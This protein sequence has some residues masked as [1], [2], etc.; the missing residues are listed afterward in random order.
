M[1]SFFAEFKNFAVR[2]NVVELAV[3]VIIGTAFGKIVSS[4]VDSIIMPTI[5]L[6]LG[7]INFS[8]WELKIGEV[9]IT[10]GKFIQSC[11]DFTIVA[12]VIFLAIKAMQRVK[13]EPE[14]ETKQ[15][16]PREEVKILREIRDELKKKQQ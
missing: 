11:V 6:I 13:G 12:F 9:S 1:K 2:G 15:A 8:G 4:L 16:E 3:A 7:G 14:K 5:G 10:Y